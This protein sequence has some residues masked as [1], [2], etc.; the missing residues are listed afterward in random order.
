V[1]WLRSRLLGRN[2]TPHGT[3]SII[4]AHGDGDT[5]TVTLVAATGDSPLKALRDN[6]RCHRVVAACPVQ[7]PWL[8]GRP[9]TDVLPMAG[10][11]D[12]YRRFV[13]DDRPVVTGF[14]AVG[15]A[16]AC[17]NPSAGRGLSAPARRRLPGGA[18]DRVLSG[19][20]PGGLPAPGI[21]R[22]ART[23]TRRI[24]YPGSRP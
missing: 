21:P 10:A 19:A 3:F 9:I 8:D 7:A 17:T 15:D 20:A 16:W 2:L 14:A 12:R 23:G 6:D 4:T 11:V 24:T 18:G 22:T 1:A 5:W 13:V